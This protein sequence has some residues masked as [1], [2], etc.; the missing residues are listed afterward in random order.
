MTRRTRASLAALLVAA[1]AA[2]GVLD[3][4]ASTARPASG[5]VPT[6]QDLHNAFDPGERGHG[7]L[8]VH[9]YFRG[10]KRIL[11]A[12][13]YVDPPRVVRWVKQATSA[14]V[15]ESKAKWRTL[16]KGTNYLRHAH[17]YFLPR[18]H[19]AFLRAKRG[20]WQLRSH[21]R[22]VRIKMRGGAWDEDERLASC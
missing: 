21:H 10:G 8:G 13:T 18:R 16:A 5:T 1:A 2:V 19:A 11:V 14:K 7:F 17:V 9:H 22:W 15:C 12:I 20:H 6:I 3:A 4:G